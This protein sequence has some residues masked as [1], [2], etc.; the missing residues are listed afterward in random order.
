MTDKPGLDP[1]GAHLERQRAL[2][3]WEQQR[4]AAKEQAERDRKQAALQNYL[5]RRGRDW[6]ATVGT[7][8]PM[9]VLA[10]WQEEFMD[11]KQ[12]EAEAERAKKLAEIEASYDY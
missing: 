2:K 12:R 6:L 10:R 5:E 1:Y 8:P 7:P 9:D 11:A 4:A 3:E